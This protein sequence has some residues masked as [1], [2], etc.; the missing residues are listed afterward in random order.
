M[1]VGQNGIPKYLSGS[2]GC[3][4]QSRLSLLPV[5]NCSFWR[6]HLFVKSLRNGVVGSNPGKG[7][8][9]H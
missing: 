2:L 1:C 4:G 6:P 9:D 7:L 3:S 5:I 8:S